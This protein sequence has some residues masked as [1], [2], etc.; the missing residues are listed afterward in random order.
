MLNYTKE[1][2]LLG[3]AWS[4][5]YTR[6][7]CAFGPAP[8]VLIYTERVCIWVRLDRAEIHPGGLFR[9]LFGALRPRVIGLD[10]MDVAYSMA[11]RITTWNG[12]RFKSGSRMG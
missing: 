8:I 4:C 9:A 3:P 12:C 7:R 2:V 6:S 11:G 1:D 5:W 10:K